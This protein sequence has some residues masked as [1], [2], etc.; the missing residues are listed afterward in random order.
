[1]K[2]EFITNIPDYEGIG[3]YALVNNRNGKMYIGSS[4]NI[5]Q[6]IIHHK[7]SPPST[8]KE[9]IY[10]GD[11]FSAKN[12]GKITLWLQSI[13]YVQSRVTLYSVL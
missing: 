12:T 13:R 3:V 7:Y 5:R 6:R 9:D 1:M 10:Q 2:N 11:T 4:Q 8:V